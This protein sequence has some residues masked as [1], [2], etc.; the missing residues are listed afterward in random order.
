[1][2]HVEHSRE[3]PRTYPP[4]E[5]WLRSGQVGQLQATKFVM[6][7]GGKRF[8]LALVYTWP[9]RRQGGDPPWQDHLLQPIRTWWK[10]W[11]L[12]FCSTLTALARAR[13]LRCCSAA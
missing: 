11:F 10:T 5:G 13:A 12:A 8:I 1:M 9:V 2:P 4:A 7:P 3:V 6:H